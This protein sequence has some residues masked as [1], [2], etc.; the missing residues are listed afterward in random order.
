MNT[1]TM[2]KV[3][4]PTA[5]QVRLARRRWRLLV[6]V[7][8][9]LLALVV[10]LVGGLWAFVAL[11]T[12]QVVPAPI[13]SETTQFNGRYLI[14]ASDADMVSTAY[15]DGV[16]MRVPGDVDTLS[17]IE[18]PLT[19]ADARVFELPVSNSVTSWP[20]IIAVAPD[21]EMIYVVETAGQVDEGITQ[22]RTED[23]P[24]GRLLTVI[25]ISAGV[26]DAQ[27]T[28]VDVGEWPSHIAISADGTYL[29]IGLREESRQ[30]AILPTATLDDP[31]TFRYFPVQRA[32][33]AP[34]GEVSSVAWHPSGDFLAGGVDSEQL[35][36]FR[37]DTDIDGG[38]SLN[39]HG[40]RQILGNTI[41]YGQFTRSGDFYLTAEINWNTAPRPMGNIVNPPGEMIAV[42]FD[43][44]T[45]AH[46]VVSRVAVGLSPEGFAVSPQED[47]VVTVNM[48]RTYLP[49]MLAGVTPGAD[50]NSLSLLR[51]DNLT[52]E[53]V[54]L[55]GEYGFEGVL[56]EH[57]VFDADGEALAVVIYN[58]RENPMNPGYVEFW[59]VVRAG[60]DAPRLERTSIRVPV[61]RGGHTM[62]L[63]P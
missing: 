10:L 61:V 30:L 27:I 41:T 7:L 36:F 51:F 45:A 56:P 5:V 47:L 42:R 55:G 33:D 13:E 25:D 20:Q 54:V 40:E 60:D 8:L 26:A 43:A 63:I 38:I 23:F 22:L 21:G 39:P 15:A 3:T 28:T 57:A 6:G 44:D 59:N 1:T 12:A 9:G 2:D 11:N 29:A 34:A 31:T 4:T 19:D 16:L 14:V 48:R 24:T 52:G 17:L 46:A 58:E 49:D 50:L 32:D 18:L 37:V 62:A 53:L 35:Q